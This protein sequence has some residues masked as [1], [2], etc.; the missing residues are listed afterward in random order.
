MRVGEPISI[1]FSEADVHVFDE[2][3]GELANITG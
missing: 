1:D 3:G 2:G